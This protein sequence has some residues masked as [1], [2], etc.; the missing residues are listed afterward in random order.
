M[1]RHD[2]RAQE[3]PP[4]PAGPRGE[5]HDPRAHPIL[6]TWEGRGQGPPARATNRDPAHGSGDAAKDEM[7]QGCLDLTGFA[8][9]LGLSYRTMTR[10]LAANLL[11]AADLVISG[12][13]RRWMRRTIEVW[14][15]S[16]P[17]LPGRGRG[18]R[19]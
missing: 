8:E 12:N 16:R 7:S 13:Q 5:V 4:G 14:L 3:R 1:N 10:L 6:R 2:P 18:A 15:K 17:R 9:F 11:P 19:R